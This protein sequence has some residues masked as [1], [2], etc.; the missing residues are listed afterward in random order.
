[1]FQNWRSLCQ[2]WRN[3][4]FCIKFSVFWNFK[5][6]RRES[7]NFKKVSVLEVLV[8]GKRLGKFWFFV[9]AA[10]AQNGRLLVLFKAMT[11]YGKPSAKE[12][13]I[14]RSVKNRQ[15]WRK[16][17][18]SGSNKIKAPRTGGNKK[19]SFVVICLK[20]GN[21]ILKLQNVHF[22]LCYRSP[23]TIPSNGRLLLLLL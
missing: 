8:D 1:M 2:N 12:H 11:K 17:C 23:T 20:H 18:R 19:K 9:L 16:L 3:L 4:N 7:W 14:W 21:E 5:F 22:Q 10:G 6:F 15:K 13:Q